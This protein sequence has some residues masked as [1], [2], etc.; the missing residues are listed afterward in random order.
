VGAG[1]HDP[2]RL[3]GEGVNEDPVSLPEFMCIQAARE[4]AGCGVAFVGMG[5]PLL[6]T[7]LAK[8]HHDPEIVFTTELGIADWEPPTD[9]VDHAPHGIG[10]PILNRGAGFV[11]DMVDALGALL[12]G[13]RVETAVLTGA[14]V[15]RYGNLNALLVGDPTQPMSRFP[16]TGGNTDAACLAKRVVTIMSLEP[17]RFVERVSFLT[18][19]GYICGPGAREE[20]GLEP[21]GPN[22]VVSTMGVFDFDTDDGGRTGSCQLRLIK[23]YPDVEP[24]VV[25]SLIPWPLLIADCVTTCPPPTQAELRLLRALDP[26]RIYLR[27]GRY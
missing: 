8:L 25:Q 26:G 27:E 24:E 15:D 23:T 21:Q 19:P 20:A 10:D 22:L 17:R 12:M 1:T 6:A 9:E 3:E 13:G 11:G 2:V 7:T 16:G 14:E 4:L 18:S 5:L